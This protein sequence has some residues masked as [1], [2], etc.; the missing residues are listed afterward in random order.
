MISVALVVCPIPYDGSFMELFFTGWRIIQQ[1]IAAD[2]RLP[3]PVALPVPADRQVAR[4]LEMRRDFPILDV[5]D[6]LRA[7]AQND[8]LEAAERNVDVV[9]E[10]D[11]NPINNDLVL[12]PVAAYTAV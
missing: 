3:T 8:L 10:R 7:Q 4:E 2:A 11:G 12:S 6:A 9:V 1:F 5:I